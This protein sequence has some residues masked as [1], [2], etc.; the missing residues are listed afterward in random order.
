MRSPFPG[1]DP[2]LETPA[3]WP[4]FHHT[5]LTYLREAIA[6]DLPDYY[7]ARI[8]ERVRFTYFQEE[9]DGSRILDL[10]IDRPSY[11]PR[12]PKHKPKRGGTGTLEL[13]PVRIP[14]P[15][16]HEIRE[17]WINIFYRPEHEVVTVLELLSPTNKERPGYDHFLAKRSALL[18]QGVQIVEIDLLIGGKRMPMRAPLPRGDYHATIIRGKRHLAD[19]YSWT[20]RDPLPRLPIPLK[21]PDEDVVCHLAPVF[22]RAYGRG[23]YAPVLYYDRPLPL[24]LDDETRQWAE[25][26]G[27]RMRRRL[28]R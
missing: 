11:A 15:G 1:M 4:D 14:L 22:A 3:F 18:Q 5:F 8:E 24:P 13:E 25:G 20:L 21:P 7:E 2:Y 23:R 28:A 27:R 17:A 19:V 26:L 9:I 12:M 16:S 10:V 6:G